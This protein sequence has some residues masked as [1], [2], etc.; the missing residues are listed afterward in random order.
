MGHH[1]HHTPEEGSGNLKI[2]FFLNF[3]FTIFEI[4][5]GFYTN[6]TAILSDALHDLG[7]S[8]SLGLAWY[9]QKYS[10]KGRDK[11][12]SYGYKRFSLLGAV[13]NSLILLIGSVVILMEAIPR[14][15]D[16]QPVHAKGMLLFA[17]VGI[18]VNGA[19]ALRLRGGK[20]LNERVVSL[21]LLEDVLGWVA[22]L[23]VSIV[24]MFTD[25]PVLDPLLSVGITIYILINVYK[26]LRESSKILLQATPADIDLEE[27]VKKIQ[28]HRLVLSVH[29]MHIW[30]LDGTHNVLTL[31]VVLPEKAS[32]EEAEVTKQELR[33]I[34]H[35]VPVHHI[36]IE[37]ERENEGCSLDEH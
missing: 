7:D 8:F 29:D 34:L 19:A 25:L 3:G 14:I 27:L 17:V 2:A 30:T 32:M 1:H 23:I 22:V 21:H 20:S 36:T 33:A 16:P 28:E 18:L 9:L 10:Q 26:N 12:F 4:F 5:G 13:I 35:H 31:H 11:Y 24:L 6:S 15:F 37:T